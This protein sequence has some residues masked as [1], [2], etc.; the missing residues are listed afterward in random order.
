[1]PAEAPPDVVRLSR[2]GELRRQGETVKDKV[3]L[4]T[5]AASGIGKASAMLLGRLGARVVL[6]SLPDTG[7]EQVARE[8]ESA[9]GSARFVPADV[10]KGADCERAVRSAVETFGRLD[11]AMNNAGTFAMGKLLADEDEATWDRVHS[12]NLKGVFLCMKHEIRAMLATGGGAIVNTSS[13]AGLVGEA[14]MAIYAASKH[15]VIGL[16]RTAALEYAQQN[17]RINA[18]CPGGTRTNMFDA[19]KDAPGFIEMVNSLHPVGRMGEPEEIA[20][21]AVFL[22]SP[23]ASFITGA[24]LAVDGGLTAR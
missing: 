19:V 15:G 14:T 18:I 23:E 7:G 3:A 21:A 13:I 17:I 2:H 4:V 10:S 11:L 9:G 6:V 5:G 20:A 22:L 1:M 8:I 24:T 12:V 16:T